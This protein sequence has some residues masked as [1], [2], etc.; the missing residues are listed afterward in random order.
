MYKHDSQLIGAFRSHPGVLGQIRGGQ[1]VLYYQPTGSVM[2]LQHRLPISRS[3]L[4]DRVPIILVSTPSF[5]PEEMLSAELDGLVLAG[6]GTGSLPAAMIQ[7]LSPTWTFKI[8]IVIV[9]RCQTGANHDD[10]YYVGS[11][12]KYAS[13]GFLVGGPY[14]HLNPLQARILLILRLSA[15]GHG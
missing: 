13:K 3:Q 1:P 9:S 15:L 14:E 10:F 2:S 6:S 4:K 5:F 7:L 11:R 8:P 12:E